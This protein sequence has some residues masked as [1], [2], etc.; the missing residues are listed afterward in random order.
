VLGKNL[1]PF[2]NSAPKAR[3]GW[4]RFRVS[5]VK[6][7]AKQ[8]NFLFLLKEKK[9]GREKIKKCRENFSVLPVAAAKRKRAETLG[10][11]Q[12]V[13]QYC[14]ID[15]ITLDFAQRRFGFRPTNTAK[16]YFFTKS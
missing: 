8:K 9:M 3:L 1:C 14:G 15:A 7:K 11:I 5:S 10:G 12:S 16:F 13:P 2:A 6:R 4:E